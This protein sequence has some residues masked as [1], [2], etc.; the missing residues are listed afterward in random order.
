MICAAFD[1]VAAMA[2]VQDDAF[3]VDVSPKFDD[4]DAKGQPLLPSDLQRLRVN[5]RQDLVREKYDW[6]GP[7][8]RFLFEYT[9]AEAEEAIGSAV[10]AV[11]DPK[12][13]LGATGGDR[14]D[15]AINTIYF[16]RDRHESPS[17]HSAFAVRRLVRKVDR[18]F[19]VAAAKHFPD[20]YMGGG[21]FQ[22]DVFYR[23]DYIAKH[24]TLA[25]P[26]RVIRG[27][28][29]TEV[30]VRSVHACLLAGCDSE[31]GSNYL[32]CCAAGMELSTW[33]PSRRILQSWRLTKAPCS[34]RCHSFH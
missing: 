23:L 33:V 27:A 5:R 28:V 20:G 16:R 1:I 25:P 22:L 30:E 18:E 29:G 15:R 4:V 14:S 10:D 19:V 31:L 17:L 3:W 11:D 6:V 13:L 12:L 2:A 32:G 24:P 9:L 8:A 26:F 7:S 21:A 34:F